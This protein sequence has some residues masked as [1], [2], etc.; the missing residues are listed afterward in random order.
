MATTRHTHDHAKQDEA[1]D[2]AA[3]RPRAR[4]RRA[5]ARGAR[6]ARVQRRRLR[7]P[8][9]RAR[10]RGAPATVDVGVELPGEVRP[11][12]DRIAHIAPRFPGSCARSGSASATRS[13][14]ARC[15]PSSRARTSRPSSCRRRSTASV[16][17]KPRRA[18]RGGQ[19]R[20][21][22]VHR[23]R[24]LDGL[25][26]RARLPERARGAAPRAAG[27]HL[28]PAH[29]D[30]EADGR[31]LV[32]RAHRRP[33]DAHGERARRLAEPRRGRGGRALRH[34]DGRS[35]PVD[36]AGGRSAAARSTRWTDSAVV[37]VVEGER[38]APRPVTVGT[39]RTPNAP[40]SRAAS[41][42]ATATPTTGSFLVKAELAKGEGGH[43]H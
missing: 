41:P 22:G 42:P 12:A 25:G 1:H 16:I 34:R 15:S 35:N 23:R 26:R 28:G 5:R 39:D 9:R 38:F 40:R 6:R 4:R 29:G 30:R 20:E 13:A 21:A 17:D 27:A 2:A 32:H 8:R 36:G 7:A 14:P 18:R 3:R 33:G 31:R 24:P 43:E 19:P 37:F 10:D 11:N